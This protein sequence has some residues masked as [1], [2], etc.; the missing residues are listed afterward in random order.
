V[1]II[2]VFLVLGCLGYTIYVIVEAVRDFL[3]YYV[4]VQSKINYVN[5]GT[6]T[7]PAAWICYIGQDPTATFFFENSNI[8][9]GSSSKS[10]YRI[11]NY[12]DRKCF[13]WNSGIASDDT[14]IDLVSSKI[15]GSRLGIKIN[16]SFTSNNEAFLF[17]G[18]NSVR[19][20][21][22]EF[23]NI[24]VIKGSEYYISL[25][26][27][28]YNKLPKPF[29][30]CSDSL[31]DASSYDS[32]FYSKVFEACIKYRQ[33]NCFEFCVLKKISDFCDCS[34]PGFNEVN[35]RDTCLS[36]D[37]IFALSEK[38]EFKS[39]RLRTLLST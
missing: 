1:K 21:I 5:S 6:M 17:V 7:L 23:E 20:M 29:N 3:M 33:L 13:V 18:D 10:S 19:P 31:T 2:W 22:S 28:N 14:K 25:N 12:L 39:K 34:F 30:N 24:R 8:A 32:F 26:K 15:A 16:L 37:Y 9:A 36:K 27:F 35:E 4:I 11:V 38:L